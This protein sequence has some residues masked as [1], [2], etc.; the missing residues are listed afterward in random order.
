MMGPLRE[1]PTAKRTTPVKKG[2]K[3]MSLGPN[4]VPTLLLTFE[5]DGK[6]VHKETSGFEGKKCTEITKFIEDAL[7]GTDK[8]IT[9]KP[10]FYRKTPDSGNRITA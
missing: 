3:P 7:N 1:S 5:W 9:F 8:K 10:E 6:T 2:F 4:Q